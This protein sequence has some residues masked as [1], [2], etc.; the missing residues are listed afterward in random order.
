MRSP[1][2]RPSS[3]E[4]L[5]LHLPPPPHRTKKQPFGL[6][7]SRHTSTH[8][9]R[10]DKGTGGCGVS[11]LSPTVV[12][13]TSTPRPPRRCQAS[14][15]GPR[16]HLL[17]P[18]GLRQG[19]AGPPRCTQPYLG[20]PILMSERP[21]WMQLPPREP[22]LLVEPPSPCSHQRPDRLGHCPGHSA[23]SHS[24]V[25]GAGNPKA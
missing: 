14:R 7:R 13:A 17:L 18:W 10:A 16:P 9:T 19:P 20:L 1:T 22:P 11:L 6:D 3:A 21:G 15:L 8:K 4:S 2:P 5:E 25:R 12:L 23:C 24:L